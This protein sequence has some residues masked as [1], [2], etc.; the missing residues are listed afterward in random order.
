MAN[1]D[2]TSSDVDVK[3]QDPNEGLDSTMSSGHVF[4]RELKRDS[5]IAKR[6]ELIN[7]AINRFI[8]DLQGEPKELYETASY[9]LRAGGK[10]LR[11]LITVLSCEAVGGDPQDVMPFAIAVELVQTASLIHDDIIDDDILR[12]GV[13]TTHKKFGSRI[14]VLAGDLLV[15]QAIHL[16][17]K[18][19]HPE[20]LR[21]AGHGGILLCEGEVSDMLMGETDPTYLT[22]EDYLKMIERKTAA[23][24]RV[25]AGVGVL[26]GG[27]S[28]EEKTALMDYAEAIG[29]AF[30]IRDDILNLTAPQDVT[31]KSM[32]TDLK[33]ERSNFVLVHC[34]ETVPKNLRDQCVKALQDT[35]IDEVLRIIEENGSIEF[36]N[37]RAMEYAE[38]AKESI[39]EHA[40]S[41]GPLLEK[42][43]DFVVLRGH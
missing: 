3:P 4:L 32:L 17:G 29:M 33:W 25:A 7:D 1:R 26:V 30:Q 15:A 2:P 12:R 22:T 14:A 23:L 18:M 41:I 42:I 21:L 13:E 36:A 37:E 9:L 19:A 20:L 35:K 27:G 24:M 31:G 28:D 43:A 6:M 8:D 38:R 39:R 40:F 5:E 16:I 11:S 34:L 10:R